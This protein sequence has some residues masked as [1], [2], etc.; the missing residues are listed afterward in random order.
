MGAD[1]AAVVDSLMKSL[2]FDIVYQSQLIDAEI[3]AA[4]AIG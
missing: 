2:P 1:I 3:S 4:N